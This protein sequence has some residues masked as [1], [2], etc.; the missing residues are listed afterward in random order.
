MREWLNDRSDRKKKELMWDR[1]RR[2]EDIVI[3][4]FNFIK[5]EECKEE[6]HPEVR[7]NRVYCMGFLQLHE[8]GKCRAAEKQQRA[9]DDWKGHGLNQGFMEAGIADCF[10]TE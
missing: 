9:A 8:D 4:V 7:W 10:E 2:T 3:W 6:N 5:S 1:V